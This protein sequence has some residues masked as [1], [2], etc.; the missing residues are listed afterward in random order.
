MIPRQSKTEKTKREGIDSSGD[1]LFIQT[2]EMSDQP[3]GIWNDCC[4][5][6]GRQCYVPALQRHFSCFFLTCWA[7][8]T[9]GPDGSYLH[10]MCVGAMQEYSST[11]CSTVAHFKCPAVAIAGVIS[12]PNV[13]MVGV[14]LFVFQALLKEQLAK[15]EPGRFHVL[16][17]CLSWL[18]L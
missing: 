17:A 10:L 14:Y 15:D 4:T 2:R 16:S 3:E 1:F 5:D 6:H 9:F 8:R 18:D 12:V 11:Y 7:R 13:F